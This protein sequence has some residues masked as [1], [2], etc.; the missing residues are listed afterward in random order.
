MTSKRFA[1]P[2]WLITIGGS[3]FI[4]ALAVSAAFVPEIRWLHVA[5]A[6]IYV[7]TILLSLRQ[8]CWGYYIGISAAGF[9]SLVAMFGSPL[10]AELI[11]QPAR[12][13]LILQG[14]A[15]LANL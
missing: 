12:P 11:E 4:F 14:M 3:F 9:W 6:S 13:D 15:W 10:F 2:Q 5:Q 7:V 1:G 8:N